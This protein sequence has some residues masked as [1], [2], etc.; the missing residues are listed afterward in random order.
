MFN[1]IRNLFEHPADRVLRLCREK[2]E[3]SI[4]RRAQDIIVVG[5]K[6]NAFELR[7]DD[8]LKLH[9]LLNTTKR[10]PD[11]NQQPTYR[12]AIWDFVHSKEPE[13]FIYNTWNPV[14]IRWVRIMQVETA[15]RVW[16]V[17]SYQSPLWDSQ[18]STIIDDVMFNRYNVLDKVPNEQNEAKDKTTTQEKETGVDT[19]MDDAVNTHITELNNN[20][21]SLAPTDSCMFK[22]ASV[23]LGKGDEIHIKTPNAEVS[24]KG[25]TTTIKGNLKGDIDAANTTG[26]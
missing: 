17:E 3:A 23:I 11:S 24:M 26:A 15:G 5:R 14:V 25:G 6:L 22:S 4:Q 18:E 13:G 7:G 10:N 2:K 20:I 9:V 21:K 8:F 1:F 12:M 19:V 16:I